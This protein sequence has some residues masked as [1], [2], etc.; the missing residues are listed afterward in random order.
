MW[1]A[2]TWKERWCLFR[3]K[4]LSI[5]KRYPG[6]N[7]VRCD[8]CGCEFGMNNHERIVLPWREVSEAY[9]ELDRLSAEYQP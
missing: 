7:R 3:H 9:D 8:K 5:V 6:S 1:F 2:M 4:S